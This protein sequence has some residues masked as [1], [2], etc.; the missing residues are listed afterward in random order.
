MIFFFFLV[1]SRNVFLILDI[2][3]NAGTSKCFILVSFQLHKC[4]SEKKKR[5]LEL[6]G[7]VFQVKILINL[8]IFELFENANLSKVIALY[9]F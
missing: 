2:L 8:Q 5:Y 3:E 6:I 4:I 1:T 7:T 9:Y